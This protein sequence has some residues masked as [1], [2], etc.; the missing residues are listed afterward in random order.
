M[1]NLY[2]VPRRLTWYLG[3]YLKILKRKPRR[4]INLDG[5]VTIRYLQH[6]TTYTYVLE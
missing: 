6:F 5:K 1:K 4:G 2:V 3:M